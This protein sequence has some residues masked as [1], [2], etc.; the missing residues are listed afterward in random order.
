MTFRKMMVCSGKV[1]I[2]PKSAC[3]EF[4]TARKGENDSQSKENHQDYV[5]LFSKHVTS[6]INE[7]LLFLILKYLF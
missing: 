3:F 7:Y 2:S 1:M 5:F 4:F 6:F